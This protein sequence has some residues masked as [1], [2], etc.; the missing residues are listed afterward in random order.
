MHSPLAGL[1]KGSACQNWRML[2]R[3]LTGIGG[4]D[5]SGLRKPETPRT[6]H[7]PRDLCEQMMPS[8]APWKVW[9]HYLINPSWTWKINSPSELKRKAQ[10][11]PDSS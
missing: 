7:K 10:I 11:L 8:V 4:M 2:N 1:I 5:G 6:I 9:I 3:V